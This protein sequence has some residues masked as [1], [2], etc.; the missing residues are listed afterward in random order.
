[1]WA[2]HHA[3]AAGWPHVVS[4]EQAF[5]SGEPSLAFKAA[6]RSRRHLSISQLGGGREEVRRAIEPQPPARCQV[7]NDLLSRAELI[8]QRRASAFHHFEQAERDQRP[9][10]VIIKE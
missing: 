2:E 4:G 7:Q 1:M 10:S 3:D 6:L 5:K 9:Q 8:D